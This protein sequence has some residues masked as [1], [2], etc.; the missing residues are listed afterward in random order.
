MKLFTKGMSIALL[1]LITASSF[2]QSTQVKQK[3]FDAYPQT[4]NVANI[5]LS[6][7]AN[8]TKGAVVTLD[9]LAGFQFTGTVFYNEK[10]Y[11][12]LQT[13]MIRSAENPKSVFEISKITRKD[14][15]IA[16]VGR[17]MNNDAGDG[18]ELKNN[19]GSYSLQKFDTQKILEECK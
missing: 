11:D 10:K 3:I 1:S 13:I 2:A 12:N 7:A 5:L 17:I 14:N 18:Y 16:Y 9:L 4:I 8:Y 19:N 15:S 6:N